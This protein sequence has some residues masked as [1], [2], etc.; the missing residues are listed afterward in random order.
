M[1]SSRMILFVT[2]R[3]DIPISTL[4]ADERLSFTSNTWFA[5][6]TTKNNTHARVES[7][8]RAPRGEQSRGLGGHLVIG[9]LERFTLVSELVEDG[10][11]YLLV[12]LRQTLGASQPVAAFVQHGLVSQQARSL[13]R[14]NGLPQNKNNIY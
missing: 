1:M 4:R 2:A 13:A 7:L 12:L 3:R 14:R 6:C 10:N 5:V 8:Q 9:A 11:A